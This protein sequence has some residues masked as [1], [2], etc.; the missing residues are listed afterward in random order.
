MDKYYVVWECFFTN[1]VVIKENLSYTEATELCSDLN[2]D[3][4]TYEW[5]EVKKHE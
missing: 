1:D 3:S 2:T 5:A 4:D